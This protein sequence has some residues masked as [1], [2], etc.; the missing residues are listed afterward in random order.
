MISKT[1]SVRT[2][3]HLA[4]REII[5]EKKADPDHPGRPHT[6][7]V[8]HHEAQ[9]PHD[10]RSAL[11]QNFAFPQRLSHQRKFVILEIAQAAMNQLGRGRRCV[12]SQIVLLCK[13]NAPAP[14]GEIPGDAGAI[15]PT[16]DHKHVADRRGSAKPCR[17][18]S[19]VQF[20]HAVSTV[21]R[22]LVRAPLGSL[23]L[24]LLTTIQINFA[25]VQRAHA[26]RVFVYGFI[27]SFYQTFKKIVSAYS[28]FILPFLFVFLSGCR[29]V[30]P[31]GRA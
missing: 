12:A 4:P 21:C 3:K 28:Q 9:R 29:A 13:D 10:V 31:Q 22:R 23:T 11:E 16:P 14:P 20:G 19:G 26:N 25:S 7:V 30:L 27:C 17:S 1:Q 24:Y 15:D 18:A 5:V 2:G 8:R 6:R